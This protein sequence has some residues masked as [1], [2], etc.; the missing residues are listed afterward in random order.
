MLYSC[1][2]SWSLLLLLLLL[3][4]G[5]HANV[6]I[7]VDPSARTAAS[8]ERERARERE[9]EGESAGRDATF[10]GKYDVVGTVHA[11][12]DAARR[13]LDKHP[14]ED[15]VIR[16]APGTHH[17]GP[18]P[19]EIGVEDSPRAGT[20]VTWTSL[21]PSSPATIS[22]ALPVTGWKAD[23][24]RPGVFA[25]PLPPAAAAR[26]SAVRHLWVRGKRAFKP[27]YYPVPGSVAVVENSSVPFGADLP[28]GGYFFNTSALDPA[29]FRNPTN[30]EFVYTGR[31]GA[32]APPPTGYADGHERGVQSGE[33]PWT[34]MRCTVASVNNRSVAL[35]RACWDA[36]PFAGAED[37]SSYAR[38]D[39][40]QP[41]A[42]LENVEVNF[43]EA[44]EWYLD[45]A[46]SK[47]LYRPR[48]GETIADVEESAITSVNSTLLVLR[49]ARHHRWVSVGFEYAV[50]DPVSA[51]QRG[52]VDIQSGQIFNGSVIAASTL[53]LYGVRNV[54]FTSCDFRRLGGVY[55]ITAEEGSQ[56]VSIENST[57]SDCTYSAQ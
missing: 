15:I 1:L 29:K 47:I 42:Y 36:L 13:L 17:V 25:A 28:Y 7:V 32:R 9:K 5:S 2:W 4:V 18:R 22:G 41:P 34:E 23:A 31:V 48:A 43:T 16:L 39:R 44:G 45:S 26:P 53:Q 52:Y 14:G 33:D 49:G 20:T 8:A 24:A 30:V 35:K 56:G 55:A 27:R 38:S 21:D 10:Y 54:S 11:A 12:R 50:W 37:T 51:E 46:A 3:G 40:H 6:E 19:L 57:F